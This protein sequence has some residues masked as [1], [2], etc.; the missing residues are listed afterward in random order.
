[1]GIVAVDLLR[2][3]TAT[4][5][6]AGTA[7]ISFGPDVVNE[8]W[9]VTRIQIKS[10]SDT[11]LYVRAAC[12][13]YRQVVVDSMLVASTVRGLADT[14]EGG[15]TLVGAGRLLVRFSACEPGTA[16]SVTVGGTASY[17]VY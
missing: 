12:A 10:M 17:A 1:M 6:A 13:I 8:E 16:C 14:W 2:A 11:Q 3:Y 4:A 7:T 9:Y 5:D 15:E